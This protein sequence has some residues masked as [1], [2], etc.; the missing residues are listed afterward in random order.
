LEARKGTTVGQPR[1]QR[2]VQSASGPF[3]GDRRG[4]DTS[5]SAGEGG[6]SLLDVDPPAGVVGSAS[7]AQV[8][9]DEVVMTA[10]RLGRAAMR[11]VAFGQYSLMEGEGAVVDGHGINHARRLALPQ[12]LADEVQRGSI[13]E[14]IDAGNSTDHGVT[15][16]APRWTQRQ[17]ATNARRSFLEQGGWTQSP[18]LI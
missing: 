17:G 16:F 9:H 3:D 18:I 11:L 7:G 1:L 8:V 13:D 15:R 6:V 10:T 4:S 2:L 12:R 5:L 14:A